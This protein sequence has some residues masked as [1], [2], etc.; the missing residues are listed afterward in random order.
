MSVP[1]PIRDSAASATFAVHVQPRARRTAIAGVRGEAVKLA[2]ASPA[3]EDRAN[4]CLIDF[5]AS[6]FH[7]PRSAVQILAGAHSRDKVIRISGRTAS[8]LQL[9]LREHFT[10]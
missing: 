8:E 1:F 3:I 7:T 9:A 10:V 2:I 5:F 4:E 6:L